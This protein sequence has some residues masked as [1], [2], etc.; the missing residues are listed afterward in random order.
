MSQSPRPLPAATLRLAGHVG[1]TA[2]DRIAID[3]AAALAELDQHVSAVRAELDPCQRPL[4]SGS[5]RASLR[6]DP[7]SDPA[8]GRR[9]PA[10]GEATCPD[11][12]F[13]SGALHSEPAVPLP[14]LLHYA[15][16]F[17]EAAVSSGWQP[18]E[19]AGSRD[20][21]SMRLAAICQLI[22]QAEAASQLHPDL[23]TI[24]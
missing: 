15:C 10:S 14:L 19:S 20:W 18:A 16:G 5:R 2:L 21:A 22:K 9:M 24:A 11:V 12:P 7:A 17:T 3:G 23:K 8:P 1:Q 6:A 13:A 4:D